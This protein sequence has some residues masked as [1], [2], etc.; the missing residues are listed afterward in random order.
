MSEHTHHTRADN[1]GGQQ[2]ENASAEN[3]KGRTGK[4]SSTPASALSEK[5]RRE[6]WLYIAVTIGAVELLVAVGAIVYGFMSSGSDQRAFAFPWLYWAGLAVTVP[7][8]ILMLVHFADVGLFSPRAGKDGDQEWQRHL[9]ERVQRLYRIVKGAP[10][11]V[12]LLA[13]VALGA[14]LLTIDGALG[15]V[16]DFAAALKPHLPY[17]IVALAA[18]LSIVVLAVVWLNYRTRRLIAEYQFRREVLEKTGVIIVDKDSTALP[19]GGLGDV[20]YVLVSG[21]EGASSRAALPAG[22]GEGSGKEPSS[23]ENAS[24]EKTDTETDGTGRRET[25]S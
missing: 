2:P 3:G 9:P 15:L 23:G 1:A 11:A 5:Q 18:T 17:I 12:V 24:D 25:S 19:P 8:L 14:A 4:T 7:A 22:E 20:P 16:R 10:V 21:D 13:I 6:L